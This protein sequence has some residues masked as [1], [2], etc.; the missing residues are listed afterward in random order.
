METYNYRYATFQV[1]RF[2]VLSTKRYLS[3]VFEAVED[4]LSCLLALN[5]C[6]LKQIKRILVFIFEKSSYGL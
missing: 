5:F 1:M 3:H 2:K 4:V 6:F